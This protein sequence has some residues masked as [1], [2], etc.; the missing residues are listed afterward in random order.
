MWCDFTANYYRNAIAYL[1]DSMNN[2]ESINLLKAYKWANEQLNKIVNLFY[3]IHIYYLWFFS[4]AH[5]VTV[6][7]K[8]WNFQSTFLVIACKLYETMVIFWFFIRNLIWLTWIVRLIQ[9]PFFVCLFFFFFWLIYS[10][11]K[12]FRW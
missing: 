5:C 9:F 2:D 1:F 4:M 8:M 7:H 10:N 3:G 11:F 6:S 12:H